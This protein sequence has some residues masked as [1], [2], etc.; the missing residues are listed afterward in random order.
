MDTENDVLD[1]LG[2]RNTLFSVHKLVYKMAFLNPWDL[3]F[4]FVL[5]S[6][7]LKRTN[8]SRHISICKGERTKD[9]ISEMHVGYVNMAV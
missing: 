2:L 5:E 9:S 4:N 3:T 8:C 6:S 7:V 1:V